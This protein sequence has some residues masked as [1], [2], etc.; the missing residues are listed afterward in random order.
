M[1]KDLSP[2][3]GAASWAAVTAAAIF[4]LAWASPVDMAHSDPAIALVASQALLDYG[5]LDLG[6]YV[7]H[8]ELAYDFDRFDRR[9]YRRGDGIYYINEGVPIVSAPAVWLANRLGYDMLD[10]DD[11]FAV[12]N[13]V[14]AVLTAAA[15]A[16][17][18]RLGLF[19]A[20]PWP[21]FVIALV[22]TLGS[23]VASTLATGLWSA[24]YQ[25]ILI[26][27][28]LAF[29]LARRGEPL[30]LV[31]AVL[32]GA[33][34][35]AG[36]VI[37]PTTAFLAVGVLV[38]L[39]G[40]KNRLVAWSARLALGSAAAVVVLVALRLVPSIP[41]YYSPKKI[42]PSTLPFRP[43]YGALL[44]PS[45][46]LLVFSPFLVPA[47]VAAAARCRALLRDRILRLVALWIVLHVVGVSF[48]KMW[49]GGHCYGPRLLTELMPGFV[50][51]TA[52]AWRE[53]RASWP[54]RRC[55]VLARSYLVLGCVGI[56]IHSF[57]GLFNPAV[58]DWNTRPNIDLGVAEP[59]IFDWR[60]PQF[61]A[62]PKGVE[63]RHLDFQRRGFGVYRP[64]EVLS[65][66]SPDLLFNSWYEPEPGWRWTRGHAPELVFRLDAA[67]AEKSFVLAL[68]ASSV[69]RQKVD[70]SMNGELLGSFEI[71]DPEPVHRILV[72]RGGV[73]SEGENVLRLVIPGA[74][75]TDFDERVM[76]LALRTFSLEPLEE[77]AVVTFRDDA[78]FAAGFS[79][80]EDAWRWTEGT[81]ARVLYPLADADETA[82]YELELV[83]G[84][85]GEQRAEVLVDGHSVGWLE[86][87][88]AEP[89]SASL[90]LPAERVRPYQVV[91]IE[92][93]IPDAARPEGDPR[94]LGIAFRSLRIAN[95]LRRSV[96]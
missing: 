30:G 39:A 43:L 16:L 78:Y 10:Q 83:A 66:D 6:V 58:H 73:L 33:L 80:A 47:A 28:I 63:R 34:L 17:F 70:A 89:R 23:T 11:E 77:D 84:A 8:P 13:V 37:R 35:A 56:F 67:D 1:K 36:F 54:P 79:A 3:H 19:Y 12:Q 40:E 95:A 48:K 90:A 38:H 14:S 22:S 87:S 5:T 25:I 68:S 15:F 86:L 51:L 29:L 59:L 18:F 65:H 32:L 46:G 4:F 21:S 71:D 26:S 62:T 9:V 52:W 44:S 72:V 92:L 88:G 76:G 61:L 49:W 69:G 85:Y 41:K 2:G 75:P 74:R 45:R 57:Q 50:V 60:Y 91:S 94:R 55:R 96:E 82:S 24:D 42:L 7:D 64:G 31:H 53:V 27:W 81:A 93:L 20:A